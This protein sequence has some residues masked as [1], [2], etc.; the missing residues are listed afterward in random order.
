M[1]KLLPLLI[2]VAGLV[3]CSSEPPAEPAPD[4]SKAQSKFE[5]GGSEGAANSAAGKTEAGVSEQ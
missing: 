3:G 5:A 2:V 4:T 1:K